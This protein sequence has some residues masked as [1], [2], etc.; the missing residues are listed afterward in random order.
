MKHSKLWRKNRRPK[1]LK[2]L[3]DLKSLTGLN[4]FKG[5]GI[6]IILNDN[7]AVNRMYFLQP[8]KISYKLPICAISLIFYSLKMRKRFPS[9]VKR[10]TP[11][12][13]IQSVFDS[14]L[15]GNY[16]ISPPFVIEAIGNTEALLEA[17]RQFNKRKI[18]LFIDEAVQLDI[19]NR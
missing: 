16:R 13:S 19:K 6:R 9:T 14:I 2:L 8:T 18:Q 1:V 17:V 10:V 15:I 5:A 3:D 11:F 4:R 7:A 12:V